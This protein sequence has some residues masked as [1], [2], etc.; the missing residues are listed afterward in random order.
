MDLLLLHLTNTK[1][2]GVYV[3][4]SAVLYK[5]YGSLLRGGRSWQSVRNGGVTMHSAR[6]M[7]ALGDA[8]QLVISDGVGFN[9]D[10]D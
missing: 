10:G 8:T 4:L 5:A 6:G 1:F 3:C 9:A 7:H 2:K